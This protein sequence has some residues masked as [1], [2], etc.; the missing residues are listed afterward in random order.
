MKPAQT[1][2]WRLSGAPPAD[3][4]QVAPAGPIGGTG[5]AVNGSWNDA[6]EQLAPAE[7]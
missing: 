3:S 2:K 4:W 5:P 7:T 6:P 1:N